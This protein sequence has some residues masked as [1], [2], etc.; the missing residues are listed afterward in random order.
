MVWPKFPKPVSSI[1]ADIVESNEK[2]L[3]NAGL[4]STV[5]TRPF[6]QNIQIILPRAAV[7]TRGRKKDPFEEINQILADKCPFINSF[8]SDS[9]EPSPDDAFNYCRITKVPIHL[10][11]HP[12]FISS[13]VK[14]GKVYALSEG[15][16][17]ESQNSICMTPDGLLT[18][19]VT[20]RTYHRL[21]LEGRKS[22]LNVKKN[23]VPKYIIEIDLTTELASKNTSK[24]YKRIFNC[25]RKSGLRFDILIKWEPSTDISPQVSPKSIQQYFAYMKAN[26]GPGNSYLSIEDATDITSNLCGP[27]SRSHK[28]SRPVVPSSFFETHALDNDEAKELFTEDVLEW[29]GAQ[30]C[31]ISCNTSTAEPDVSDFGFDPS[32][33]VQL[34]SVSVAQ[35]TGLF[36]PRDVLSI[37][38]EV[39]VLAA[40][41]RARRK[42]TSSD[43]TDVRDQDLLPFAVVIASG[44]EETPI[45][46]TG[47]NNEHGKRTSG[48]NVYGILMSFNDGKCL[49]WRLA[50]GYDFA[51][52]KLQ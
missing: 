33:C 32:N 43:E 11:F 21:G 20:E 1:V 39:N 13:Y 3:E 8:L 31:A 15:T 44:F 5:N 25:F 41:M 2:L 28:I 30:S 14:K 37:L 51:I 16:K 42:Q 18:L 48:E 9:H 45:S 6:T 17:I 47:K 50:D 10:L 40:E 46:W 52:E 35:V 12:V 27:S 36:T 29:S 26:P 22:I 4:L 24:Y 34:G 38:E 23:A 7:S 19:S 49:F